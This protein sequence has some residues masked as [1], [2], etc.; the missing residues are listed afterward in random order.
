MALITPLVAVRSSV[1]QFEL[2]DTAVCYLIEH[3][4]AEKLQ[5]AT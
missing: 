2:A 4:L 5:A 1:R 3:Q